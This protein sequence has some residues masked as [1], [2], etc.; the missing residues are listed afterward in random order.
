MECP[1]CK[2]SIKYDKNFIHGT[3]ADGDKYLSE[4]WE[5]HYKS[6]CSNQLQT[7][8]RVAFKKNCGAPN[9]RTILGPSN[10][11]TCPQCRTCVCLS[12]RVPDS[13]KCAEITR[14]QR[15][16]HLAPPPSST[17]AEVKV[18]KPNKKPSSLPP[19]P[20]NTLK[21]SVDRRKQ[22]KPETS[23]AS[24]SSSSSSSTS[25]S[26]ASDSQ[27]SVLIT[28]PFCEY[29]ATNNAE[30]EEHVNIFHLQSYE[31]NFTSTP[32]LKDES[33]SNNN[34]NTGRNH[35]VPN[36]LNEVETLINS[37]KLA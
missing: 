27:T 18:K 14:T 8:S 21:G 28:C 23:S 31:S 20:Q 10:T 1:V 29:S 12:H 5:A 32:K 9:C 19:D 4:L 22:Q 36:S 7:D 16:I 6:G 15:L 13:H 33:S 11:F 2:K 17:I 30:A 37:C 26:S 24:S 3:N 25:S 34:A 35:I